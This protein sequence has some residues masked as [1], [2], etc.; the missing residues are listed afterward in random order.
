MYID[1]YCLTSLSPLE[2]F[3]FRFIT[4]HI[5]GAIDNSIGLFAPCVKRLVQQKVL[6]D[7]VRCP[8]KSGNTSCSALKHVLPDWAGYLAKS[9]NTVDKAQR[10]LSWTRPQEEE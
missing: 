4:P 3:R 5:Q 9:G 8:A 6:P 10:V 7:W 1:Y 2:W